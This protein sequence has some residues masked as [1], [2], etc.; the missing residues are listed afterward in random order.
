ML[1]LLGTVLLVAEP[2]P[3]TQPLEAKND[4]AIE[5]VEGLHKYID[6][7]I[8]ASA[9]ERDKLWGKIDVQDHEKQI[10]PRRERF[11]KM[12]GLVDER[13]KLNDLEYLGGP[14]TPSLILET[15][16]VKVHAVRWRA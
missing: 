6:R 16:P 2:L 4:L 9:G 11:K 3:H 12:L 15:D 14:R 5:M 13:V 10:E 7:E 1:F 8:A